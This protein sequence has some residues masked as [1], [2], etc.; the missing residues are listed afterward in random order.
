MSAARSIR[1]KRIALIACAACGYL[2]LLPLWRRVR[3]HILG[4]E[5]RVLNYH[6]VSDSRCAMTSVTPTAFRAQLAWLERAARVLPLE[7]LA[8][9][10]LPPGTPGNTPRVAL[11]FDDGYADNYEVALPLLLAA[12]MP[13]TFFLT[14]GMVGTLAILPH[15]RAAAAAHSR[16][17][18]WEAANALVA[19]GMDVGSHGMSHVRLIACPPARLRHELIESK[20]VLEQRLNRPVT[21]FAFPFGR[22]CD[23]DTMAWQAA[24]A[25]GYTIVA[26]AKYGWN[27]GGNGARPLARIDVS[28]SDTPWTVAAKVNGAMDLLVLF[29]GAR[30][31]RGLA[32]RRAGLGAETA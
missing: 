24:R 14:A 13:A 18:T 5:F 11:T 32:R 26:S 2:L 27:R 8:H 21:S 16:L 15:D 9:G 19:A 7:A 22:A 28:A 4:R 1:L 23:Y 6:S 31:R 17:M 10:G 29:E 30:F 20:A 3:E 25:A 12:R